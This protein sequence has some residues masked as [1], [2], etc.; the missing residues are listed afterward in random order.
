MKRKVQTP[1]VELDGEGMRNIDWQMA[2]AG[3]AAPSIGRVASRPAL[4]M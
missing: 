2:R 3:D 4:S 1:L